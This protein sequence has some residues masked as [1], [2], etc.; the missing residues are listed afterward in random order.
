VIPSTRNRRSTVDKFD[1]RRNELAESA[2]LTLGELGYARTSLRDIANN[3]PY[4]HGVLHYYFADKLELVVYSVRHYKA[5]CVTRYDGVVADS[6]TAEGLLDAFA[7]K[8]VETVQDEAPMHC[9]WYDLR[10]QSMFELDLREAV[11]L[12]DKTLEEMIWRVVVR[13]AELAGRPPAMTPSATYAVLDGLFQQALLG[14]VAGDASA[15]PTLVE[16]VHALMPLTL[17]PKPVDAVR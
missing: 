17:V 9:L 6:T 3:S 15:L 5:R 8:L 14:H 13:Y 10:T 7:A 1:E 11:T 4:S 12:I 16:Q 2:L